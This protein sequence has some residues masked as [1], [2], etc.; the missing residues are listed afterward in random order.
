M[1]CD[2]YTIVEI[3]A[4]TK[5]GSRAN[6]RCTVMKLVHTVY[7]VGAQVL[8]AVRLSSTS[9]NFPNL[10][11]GASTAATSPPTLFPLPSPAPHEGTESE[12]A[13]KA[14]PNMCAGIYE[15]A[16]EFVSVEF[17]TVER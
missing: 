6:A 8:G 16:V 4:T 2:T 5:R 15:H 10:P 3:T 13:V 11:V 1:Q 17:S 9:K 14:A 7:I 12:A